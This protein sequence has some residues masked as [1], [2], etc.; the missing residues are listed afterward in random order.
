MQ[1][2]P[3]IY[4]KCALESVSVRFANERLA[5]TLP[6]SAFQYICNSFNGQWH[7]LK[8]PIEIPF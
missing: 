3:L 8:L 6:A 2:K 4:L 7:G 1:S 5:N